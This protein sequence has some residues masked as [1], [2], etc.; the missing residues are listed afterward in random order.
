MVP[1]VYLGFKITNK[2]V[3]TKKA[4]SVNWAENSET[5]HPNMSCK[6]LRASVT[7]LHIGNSNLV[8]IGKSGNVL[9]N[10]THITALAHLSYKDE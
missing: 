10:E 4:K 7:W 9:T 8:G 1:S 2:T 3:K 6:F 5:Q